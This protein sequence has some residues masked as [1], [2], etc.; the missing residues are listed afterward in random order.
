MR[1][2][3]IKKYIEEGGQGSIK[4]PKRV[5]RNEESKELGGDSGKGGGDI[6]AQ[7]LD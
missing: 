2:R 5:K 3:K 6:S 7:S 1:E 4:G